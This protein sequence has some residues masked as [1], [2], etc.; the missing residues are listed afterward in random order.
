MKTSKSL[1]TQFPIRNPIL[2]L[3]LLGLVMKNYVI[4]D[5]TANNKSFFMKQNLPVYNRHCEHPHF[6][7]MKNL[8]Y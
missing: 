5:E 4:A 2:S 7:K 6:C 8:K 1:H 3:V